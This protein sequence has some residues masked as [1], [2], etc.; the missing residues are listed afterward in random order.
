MPGYRGR[1]T[2]AT[3]EV[4]ANAGRDA[5]ARRAR[6]AYVSVPSKASIHTMTGPVGTKA[7]TKRPSSTW[8]T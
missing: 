4:S 6:N 7:S 3:L 5:R 1:R 2:G 8:A